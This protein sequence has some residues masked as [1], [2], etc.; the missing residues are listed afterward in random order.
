MLNEKLPLV[1]KAAVG[2]RVWYLSVT[3]A[4]VAVEKAPLGVPEPLFLVNRKLPMVPVI[5]FVPVKL[6]PLTIDCE[7]RAT[8]VHSGQKRAGRQ[9]LTAR[10][11]DVCGDTPGDRGGNSRRDGRREDGGS[12]GRRT[13]VQKPFSQRH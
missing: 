13:P 6:T 10:P 9:H 2:R 4:P 5:T 12:E 11:A 8:K 3:K 7:V 1:T